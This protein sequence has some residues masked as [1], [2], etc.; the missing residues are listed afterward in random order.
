MWWTG[1]STAPSRPTHSGPIGAA[2]DLA[3]RGFERVDR[4]VCQ[5]L[6][7]LGA[8]RRRR[9][10]G[11]RGDECLEA[12]LDAVPELRMAEDEEVIVGHAVQNALTGLERLHHAARAPRWS[13][14]RRGPA[15]AF[16][17]VVRD[18]PAR[19]E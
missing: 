15:L 18:D 1:C 12:L 17:T 7:G 11:D 4:A 9:F 3:V 14:G 2:F 10:I 13:S 8:L 5:D 16:R 19:A 6:F